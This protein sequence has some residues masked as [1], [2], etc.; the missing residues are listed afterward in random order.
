MIIGVIGLKDTGKSTVATMLAD[1]IFDDIGE[2]PKA[3][4]F[5][6]QETKELT[7][8]LYPDT[9]LDIKHVSGDLFIVKRVEHKVPNIIIDN[10]LKKEQALFIQSIG[11]ILIRV[12]RNIYDNHIGRQSIKHR[13]P[14]RA[15]KWIDEIRPQY[16]LSSDCDG[17]RLL[18][19]FVTDLYYNNIKMLKKNERNIK[20]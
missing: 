7:N 2:V 6:K 14:E 12:H 18:N 1:C 19:F 9:G 13:F 16:H 3:F 10:I 11:G 5:N 15:E 17:L 4:F 8:M 20:N